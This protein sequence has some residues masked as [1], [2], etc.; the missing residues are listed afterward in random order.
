[1][2]PIRE[3]GGVTKWPSGPGTGFLLLILLNLGSSIDS[4]VAV[5]SYLTSLSFIN[6]I[7][8]FRRNHNEMD[9]IGL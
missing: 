5:G 7:L 1:M 4:C 9:F 3:G 8:H 6:P 2:A